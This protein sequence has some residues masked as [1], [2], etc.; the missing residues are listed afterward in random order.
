[1]RL[2]ITLPL[3]TLFLGLASACTP[4][5]YS[6]GAGANKDTVMECGVDGIP[7]PINT[8]GGGLTCKTVDGRVLC[9]P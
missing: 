9:A 6:C 1:M 3:A 8:C 4:G 5:E 7:V 2:S